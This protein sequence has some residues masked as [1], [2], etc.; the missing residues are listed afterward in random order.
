MVSQKLIEQLHFARQHNKYYYS[1][2]LYIF[3]WQRIKC[4]HLREEMT[5]RY[6]PIVHYYFTEV[7]YFIS[8]LQDE[9]EPAFR[10]FSASLS[11][12]SSSVHPD[13][14]LSTS[15]YSLLM[16]LYY[17]LKK[18]I[19]HMEVIDKR[20]ETSKCGKSRADLFTGQSFTTCKKW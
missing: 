1:C 12:A 13:S 16:L 5:R 18:Q 11:I 9:I 6:G 8:P 20:D 14:S 4:F 3:P 17:K 2:F 7:L 19:V 10:G 15:N